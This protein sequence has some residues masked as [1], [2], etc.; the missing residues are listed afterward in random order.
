MNNE[1]ENKI[2]QVGHTYKIVVN[3]FGKTLTFTGKIICIEQPFVSF[4]DRYNQVLNYNLNAIVTIE[5][6]A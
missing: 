3:S 1:T 6:V 5:E 4:T 2:L